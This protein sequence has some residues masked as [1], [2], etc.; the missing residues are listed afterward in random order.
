[1]T[2]NL[3]H[4]SSAF[5]SYLKVGKLLYLSLCL[6]LVESWFYW[7]MLSTAL[8]EK[9]LAHKIFWLCC[10]LFSF[11]HIFLVLLDGWSRF[12]NYKRI[13][14]QFFLHGFSPH[15][16]QHFIGSNCQRRAVSTA[17]RELGIEKE[18]KDFYRSKGV[19]TYHFVPYALLK[20][21]LF[22]LH[23]QFWSCTFLEKYYEPRFDYR[24]LAG[25]E[26]KHSNELQRMR[27]L[28]FEEKEG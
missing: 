23:P 22:H 12:Q 13:K 9:S 15:L 18:V 10:F 8:T 27:F 28:K 24:N 3:P 17:A 11:V 21:P 14:D 1:M 5:I 6:F 7:Q 4:Q 26:H 25:E 16:A 19:K 20:N 2:G